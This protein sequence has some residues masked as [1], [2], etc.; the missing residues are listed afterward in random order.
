M[1][2][3]KTVLLLSSILLSIPVS[4]P[5]YA[6]PNS[7]PVQA[8]VYDTE[9]IFE[10]DGLDEEYS[11]AEDGV[12][13]ANLLS[14]EEIKALEAM[15]SENGNSSYENI[16]SSATSYALSKV[17]YPYSKARRNSGSAYDCSSLVFYSYLNSGIDLSYN[18]MNTAAAIANGLV[19]SGKEVPMSD[20]R[21]GDLIFYASG[22]NGRY[23]NIS[24]VAMYLGNGMQ[25]EASS[26][27]KAVV[28]RS[29]YLSGAVI[30]CRPAS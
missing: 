9:Q 13:I 26:G 22:R 2:N 30:A 5:A 19:A 12:I 8:Q 18:G 27:R 23:R 25:V 1:K 20:L 17:G 16:V 10:D 14:N 29:S 4:V 15:P 24:H 7:T 6:T 21:A 3:R 11:V 28:A